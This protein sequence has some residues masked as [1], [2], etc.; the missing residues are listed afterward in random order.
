MLRILIA[1]DTTEGQTRTIAQHVVDAIVR[2]GKEVQVI[3]IRRPPTGFTLDG[4]DAILIGASIHM[5][6]HSRQL[7]EFVRR[8]IARLNAVHSG[9]FSVSLSA[10]GSEKERADASHFV[11]ELLQET[12][13]NPAIKATIAGGLLYREYGFLKRWMMKKIAREAGK[14]T[15]T[16]KN[17]EYTDWNAVDMFVSR[18]LVY[19]EQLEKA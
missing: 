9:F 14:D 10:A 19:L 4:F 5:S 12:G 2:S 13:W 7:S 8:H 11:E 15:D 16:S 17:H 6:K 1:Y 3:D 18:F